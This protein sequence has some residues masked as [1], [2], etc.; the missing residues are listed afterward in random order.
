MSRMQNKVAVI[1]GGNSGIGLATA[2]AFVKEG[3]KVALLGRDS[4]TLDAAVAELG[5]AALGIR[6][7]VT[8]PEDLDRLFSTVEQQLGKIDVLFVNA[9]VAQVRPID[10]V[11]EAHFDLIFGVNVK[12]AYF[13]VQKAVPLLN[14][15][16][17]VILNTSVANQ[18]GNA[19]F[20][21]YSASKAAL[22][23]LA[24]TLSAELV[25]R[26]IRVNAI[27]PGPIET[28]IYGRLELP[29]QVID[30]L[31]E[32]F[33]SRV[34]LKRFGSPDEIASGV[35]FLASADSSFILGHELVVDGGM[36][37]L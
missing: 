19:N 33:S 16:A 15:G 30:E 34:P 36:T 5:D 7:D 25:D 27:S 20:S 18:T 35:V 12:G 23:S 8:S 28:P 11:D 24:R 14:D 32:Q 2:K 1:T 9:G 31:A 6:G 10:A 13:T 37:Q 17:S 29:E 26:G 4:E 21:V 22:R 3:A